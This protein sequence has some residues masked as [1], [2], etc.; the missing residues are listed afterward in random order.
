MLKIGVTGSAGSGKSLVCEGFRRIGLATLD[1]DEIA[2]QVV[3]PGQAAYNQVVKAFGSKIVAP[4]C[5]LDRPALRR[6]IVTTKGSREKLESILH[7]VIISETVRLMDEVVHSKKKS[8]AVEVPLLFELGM[9]NLFDVVVVVTAADN[10]LVDR[11]SRR[12]GVDREGAQKLLAIQM[13]QSEKVQK[14]DYVIENRG[15]PEAV[16]KSVG[17]LYQ[18][19]V[20]QRLTK[21]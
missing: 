4:D 16:F 2:R 9:E 10:A 1:C 15:K 14:A 19:L 21:K 6:M 11:I 18:K 7:P 13:P 3:E 20:N 5:T 12:D 17:I 8:C